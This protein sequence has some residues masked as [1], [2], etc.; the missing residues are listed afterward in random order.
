MAI[1]WTVLDLGGGYAE[2]ITEHC[3]RRWY[4]VSATWGVLG[5]S[6]K[7]LGEVQGLAAARR[8]LSAYW[9]S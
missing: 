2:K 4:R 7:D 3:G 1:N 6:S 8:T 5:E 9:A